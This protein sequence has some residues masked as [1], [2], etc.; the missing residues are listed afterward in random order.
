MDDPRAPRQ[1][2]SVRAGLYNHCPQ[3]GLV[4]KSVVLLDSQQSSSNGYTI[5]LELPELDIPASVQSSNHDF[6]K[7]AEALAAIQLKEKMQRLAFRRPSNSSSLPSLGSIN[8]FVAWYNASNPNAKLSLEI[9]NG[10]QQY[11]VAQSLLSFRPLGNAVASCSDKYAEYYAAIDAVAHLIQ[12]CLELL[13]LIDE[14]PSSAEKR[15]AKTLGW[16]LQEV[17]MGAEQFFLNP[18]VVSVGRKK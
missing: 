12:L 16:T 13:D 11:F 9:A 7:M 5:S 14:N 17:W 2:E 4:P 18:E 6:T 3:Y 15:Y 10:D 8:Q 1:V